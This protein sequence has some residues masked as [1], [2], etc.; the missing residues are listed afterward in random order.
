MEKTLSDNSSFKNIFAHANFSG[1]IS[2]VLST[3]FLT[4]L[5]PFAPGTLGTLAA[6]PLALLLSYTDI[7]LRLLFLFL[8]MVIAIWS[9][10]RAQKIIGREDPDFIVIDEVVGFSVTISFLSPTFKVLCLAFILFRIFDI[11]K[12]FPVKNLEMLK[13][14]FGIVADDLMAGLYALAG[15]KVILLFFN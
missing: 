2:L 1:K 12:P 4:G 7:L 8:V 11:F 10:D 14:G 13:G 9:S 6:I 3:W 5:L 15:S